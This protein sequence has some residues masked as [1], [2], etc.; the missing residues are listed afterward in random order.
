MNNKGTG[1][2][3]ILLIIVIYAGLCFLLKEKIVDIISEITVWREKMA[4]INI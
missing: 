4:I 1:I 2:V 3:K